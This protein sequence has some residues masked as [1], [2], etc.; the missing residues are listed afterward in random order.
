[1]RLTIADHGFGEGDFVKIADGGVS[2]TCSMDNHNSV[3]AYPRSTDQMSGK[4]MDV[5]NVSKDQFDVHVGKTPSIP[6][7]ISAAQFT[8]S[9]GEMKMTIGDHDLRAGHSI[10]LAKESIVFTCFLDAHNS[11]HAYPRSNGNDPFYNK[12]LPILYDGTPLTATAGTS[13]NPTTGIMTITTSVNHGL[14]EGDSVKFKLDS[15]TFRCDEYGQS[16]DH[17]YPRATDPYANRW[18]RVLGSN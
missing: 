2:F 15:L 3:H 18:Q 14:Q 4:W 1:M 16:S 8:P 10:R 6:F 12:P 13:Y 7:T 5:R 17:T 9:T 11:T